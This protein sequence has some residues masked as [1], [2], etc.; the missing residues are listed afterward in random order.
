MVPLLAVA[1]TLV[2]LDE[3]PRLG[4]IRRSPWGV[5][6]VRR[7][8]DDRRLGEHVPLHLHTHEELDL[9]VELLGI[10]RVA[11]DVE[12]QLRAPVDMRRM[13]DLEEGLVM[14]QD[15]VNVVEVAA[16]DG[17]PVVVEPCHVVE[18]HVLVGKIGD[19]GIVTVFVLVEEVRV[20]LTVGV[21]T[22][23]HRSAEG[24]LFRGS[25]VDGLRRAPEL[26]G[27]A[28]TAAGALVIVQLDL[29]E[30]SRL[31]DCVLPFAAERT[32]GALIDT[33][34]A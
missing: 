20:L 10:G 8:V 1:G 4:G 24:R 31:P 11:A 2:D 13:A 17:E 14:R 23:L 30:H 28:L 27:R 34:A 7:D 21:P 6:H 32:G 16:G 29:F 3:E 9:R 18:R 33:Q 22:H 25:V 26:G 12:E 19:V 15:P 5:D